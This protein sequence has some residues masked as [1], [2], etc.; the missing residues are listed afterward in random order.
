M[1]SVNAWLSNNDC[2]FHTTDVLILVM[3]HSWYPKSTLEA[4][5]VWE[6]IW[7]FDDFLKSSVRRPKAKILKIGQVLTYYVISFGYPEQ[8]LIVYI[9][10]YLNTW[11]PFFSW[12]DQNNMT[13]KISWHLP[14][15]KKEISQIFSN[16]WSQKVKALKTFFKKKWSNICLK[17]IFWRTKRYSKIWLLYPDS[18][19]ASS[20]L[21]ISAKRKSVTGQR[22]KCYNLDRFPIFSQKVIWWGV[23]SL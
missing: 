23:K 3:A 14:S 6:N 9:H 1:A 19:L 16:V 7:W 12:R 17:S 18:S 11:N 22:R 5:W 8:S 13:S 15:Y 2:F 20:C 10:R 4:G 21:I